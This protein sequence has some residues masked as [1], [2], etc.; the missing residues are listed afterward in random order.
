MERRKDREKRGERRKERKG[1]MKRYRVGTS[2]RGKWGGRRRKWKRTGRRDILKRRNLKGTGAST[3]I[4]IVSASDFFK[5]A[6][7]RRDLKGT[8]ASTDISMVGASDF[9]KWAATSSI[10]HDVV[11]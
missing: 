10:R 7:G 9:F 6:G 11:I 5:W 2:D 1:E 3:D 8:G 4:T